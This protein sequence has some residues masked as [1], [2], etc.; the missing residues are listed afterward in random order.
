MPD[1]KVKGYSGTELE[2]ENVEK[3]WLSSADS[4]EEA[5]T[6]VPYTYGEV[7][8][9]MEVELDFSGGDQKL[10]VPDGMLVKEAT[11]KQPENL[12]PENIRAGEVVAGIAGEF[13]GVGEEK[14]VE[15]DFT[16]GD[17][18]ITPSDGKLLSKVDIPKP[19]TLVPENIRAGEVIAGI[20]GTFEG[21][22]TIKVPAAFVDPTAVFPFSELTNESFF[23]QITS[24]KSNAFA[25][26]SALIS[27]ELSGLTSI[28]RY[29]FSGCSNLTT[30]IFPD[31]TYIGGDAFQSCS[32]LSDVEIR[33]AIT[34]GNSAFYGCINLSSLSLPYCTKLYEGAL[35]TSRQISV[36]M[37]NIKWVGSRAIMHNMVYNS[38]SYYN[39]IALSIGN[40]FY[41][42]WYKSS[43]FPLLASTRIIA[44][45]ACDS[46]SQIYGV[47]NTA[48]VEYIG[49]RAFYACYKMKS[50]SFPRCKIVSAFAFASCSS[51]STVYLPVCSS[52]GMGVFSGTKSLYSIDLPECE[53]LGYGA[54][55]SCVVKTVNMPKCR[56]IDGNAFINCNLSNISFPACE[57]IGDGAFSLARI[58][59]VC[60]PKV[61]RLGDSAFYS[62]LTLTN[63]SIPECSYIGSYAFASCAIP[64][65]SLPKCTFIGSAAFRSCSMLSSIYLLGSELAS[66][67]S[68]ST[69][70]KT[71]ASLSVYVRKSLAE[72]YKTMPFWS[73]L[74]SRIVGLTDDEIAALDAAQEEI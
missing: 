20:P 64:T 19:E 14:T 4:T 47:S 28:A 57:S 54:F 5:P 59:S 3:I 37:P 31:A 45:C 29:A 21:G 17:M 9:G 73:S 1:I 10:S 50:A 8:D 72:I 67:N 71:H 52:L 56:Y 70:Y 41:S 34:I 69:M 26:V 23:P 13:V 49:E 25:K 46:R 22:A 33:N 74:A 58:P 53:I 63:I 66:I 60:F 18:T 24:L 39:D 11:V 40:A 44:E 42:S 48:N 12:V 32:A 15:L 7:V 38:I 68:T 30:A 2:Y 43:Y 16:D 61:T 36:Y 65:I 55:Y 62:C 51:L 35:Y 6:L 27:V